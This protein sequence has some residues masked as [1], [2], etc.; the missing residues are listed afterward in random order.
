MVT[1]VTLEEMVNNFIANYTGDG[2][3]LGK[4]TLKIIYQ[5]KQGIKKFTMNALQEVKAVE[6]ELGDT[7][8]ITLP[9]D[10]VGLCISYVNPET[11]ELMF[12]SKTKTIGYRLLARSQCRYLFDDNGFILEGS[13]YFLN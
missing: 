12:F 9:P 10:Y 11:G 13:T 8:D 6:L 4:Q 1:Y 7:L 2:T 5:F 3:I